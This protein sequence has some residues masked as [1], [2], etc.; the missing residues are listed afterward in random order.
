MRNLNDYVSTLFEEYIGF[1][2]VDE[3]KISKIYENLV[4]QIFNKY[5]QIMYRIVGCIESVNFGTDYNQA[6]LTCMAL[7]RYFRSIATSYP[8]GQGDPYFPYAYKILQGVFPVEE[9]ID[10]NVDWQDI[11]ESSSERY[12]KTD[13]VKD[14]SALDNLFLGESALNLAAPYLSYQH[15][16]TP[17]FRIEGFKVIRA[18]TKKIKRRV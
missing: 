12:S 13:S 5:P 11:F 17:P 4:G 18:A 1:D 3:K 14:V 7:G 6:A 16:F 10:A 8:P 2:V 9:L 15:Y